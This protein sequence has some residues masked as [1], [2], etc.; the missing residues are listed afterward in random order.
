MKALFGDELVGI[1]QQAATVAASVL[2]EAVVATLTQS[3]VAFEKTIN[4]RSR[5]FGRGVTEQNAYDNRIMSAEVWL[6]SGGL[7]DSFIL[8]VTADS[9]YV[10]EDK[11][12]DAQ[13]FAGQVLKSWVRDGFRASV[14]RRPLRSAVPADC[15]MLRLVLPIEPVKNR[16]MNRQLQKAAEMAAARGW[17]P[18]AEHGFVVGRDAATEGVIE[19]LTQRSSGAAPTVTIG[20]PAA[21]ASPQPSSATAAPAEPSTAHRLQKLESLR[22]TGVIS[23]AEYTARRAQIIGEI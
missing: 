3:I 11:R 15:Q 9:I 7:P 23:D 4:R 12:K 14:D 22:D 18:G 16:A 10:I 8:T 1:N 21:G 19:A 2:S 6:A 17:P 20:G 5:W 13:L